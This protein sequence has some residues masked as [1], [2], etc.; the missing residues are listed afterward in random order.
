MPDAAVEPVT[1][2]SAQGRPKIVPALSRLLTPAGNGRA[3]AT[4]PAREP[5]H[6][7]SPRNRLFSSGSSQ[8]LLAPILRLAQNPKRSPRVACHGPRRC[9]RSTEKP[10]EPQLASFCTIRSGGGLPDPARSPSSRSWQGNW[11][12]LYQRSRGTPNGPGSPPESLRRRGRSSTRTDAGPLTTKP[13]KVVVSSLSPSILLLGYHI[14][15]PIPRQVK[16]RSC[17]PACAMWGKTYAAPA[18]PR[19]R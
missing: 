14:Y 11:L 8:H 5:P 6:R 19:L 16:S 13:S 15:T 10:D 3:T 12:R 9:G 1:K 18:G 2:P 4:N 17:G 7:A